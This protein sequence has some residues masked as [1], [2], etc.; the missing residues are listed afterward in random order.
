M[1]FYTKI[2]G[3]SFENQDGISRQEIIED[4]EE[5]VQHNTPILLL[6]QRDPEN[7]YDPQAVQVLDP[8]GR[9]L[10]FLKRQVS[11]TIAPLLDQGVQVQCELAQITGQ[12]LHHHYG[13]NIKLSY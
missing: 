7:P 12:S 5:Q 8:Q 2:A 1:E 3:V 11:Q 6:L 10:G 13:I 9:P 4:L